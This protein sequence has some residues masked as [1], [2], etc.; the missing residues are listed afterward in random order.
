M[1][2]YRFIC[3]HR[4][5]W[6]V[7]EMCRVLAVS[8]S[9]FYSWR[10]RDPSPRAQETERLDG[11]IKRLY[12]ASHGRS[13]NPKITRALWTEDWTVSKNRVAKRMK[14]LGLRSIVCRRFRVTTFSEADVYGGFNF[15][16]HNVF[17]RFSGLKDLLWG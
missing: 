2:R 15:E 14:A 7:G 10:K 3:G 4:T 11:A 17:S 1:D 6:R 5:R 8:R 13:G 16:V 9:G 12:Q